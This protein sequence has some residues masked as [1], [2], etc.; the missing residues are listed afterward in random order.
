MKVV[1]TSKQGEDCIISLL[2]PGAIIGELSMI[3]GEPRAA[4]VIAVAD[5]SL[6]FDNRTRFQKY[7][8]ADPGLMSYL[9]K[10]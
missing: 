7:A 1:V 2:G 6:S 4:S 3:D 5:C 10:T 9:V 8:E